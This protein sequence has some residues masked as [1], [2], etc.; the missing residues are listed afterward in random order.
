MCDTFLGCKLTS[1]T[2]NVKWSFEEEEDDI[3]YL[4]HNLFLRHVRPRDDN[5]VQKIETKTYCWL[6]IA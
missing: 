2:N 4:Q 6:N 5:V 1:D 3:D